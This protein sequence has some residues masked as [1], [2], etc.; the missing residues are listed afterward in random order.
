MRRRDAEH[1]ERFQPGSLQSALGSGP[2]VNPHAGPAA[3]LLLRGEGNRRTQASP[4]RLA[5][6]LRALILQETRL[7]LRLSRSRYVPAVPVALRVVHDPCGEHCSG[8]ARLR[9]PAVLH[10]ESE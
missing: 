7:A 5:S 3:Y 2:I 6:F 10:I 9:P 4:A 8:V 1:C